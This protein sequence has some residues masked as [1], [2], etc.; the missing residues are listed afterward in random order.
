MIG[1]GLTAWDSVEARRGVIT[2]FGANIV[3][4]GV[5]KSAGVHE[6]EWSAE[7]E[8]DRVLE[9]DA[10]WSDSGEGGEWREE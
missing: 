5:Y 2:S 1:I 7:Q 10:R 3:S 6:R 8:F 4:E 9:C